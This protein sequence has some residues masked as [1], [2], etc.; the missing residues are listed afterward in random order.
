V[1]WVLD[2]SPSA[3]TLSSRGMAFRVSRKGAALLLLLAFRRLDAS[4]A[5]NLG[6][7]GLPEIPMLREWAGARTSVSLAAQVRREVKAIHHAC[8]GL[9]ETRLGSQL[10]GPFRLTCVP[11]ADR[12]TRQALAELYAPLWSSGGAFTSESLYSWLERTEPIWRSFYYFDKAGEAL[13]S[14]PTLDDTVTVDPLAKALASVGTARRL[15]E[16]GEY[17]KAQQAL[18]EAATAAD[19]EPN[20]P[21]R[22]HLQVMCSLERAWLSYRTADL[23]AAERW[24]SSADA[25]ATCGAL[26]RLRGRVLNLRSLVRRARGLYSASLDDLRHA[27]RLFV[28]EGDLFHL[29]AVYHNLACLIAAEAGEDSDASRRTAMFRQALSYS[30]RNEAYCRQYGIGHNSVLNKLLQVGLHR[31]LGNTNLALQVA[32]DAE[33]L[34]LESQNFPDAVRAHRHR[35]AILLEGRPARKAKEAHDSTVS[36]LHDADLRDQFRRVYE[37]ELARRLASSLPADE[38]APQVGRGRRTRRM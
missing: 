7:V 17:G 4:S 28:A 33:R 5:S 21:I 26:L 11:H 22:Q 23:D 27:A 36:V 6:W 8:P 38:A 18:A 1:G 13:S 15:R 24:L 35:V 34:A 19:E 12:A 3:A 29:F 32:A 25:T 31:E 14:L 16:L 10:K 9:V 2:Y 37:E 20:L 30:Q